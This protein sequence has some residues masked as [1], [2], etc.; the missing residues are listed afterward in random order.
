MRACVCGCGGE[1]RVGRGPTWCG[2]S[3]WRIYEGTGHVFRSVC[4]ALSLGHQRIPR[5]VLGGAAAPARNLTAAP[6]RQQLGRATPAGGAGAVGGLRQQPACA[7]PACIE[8][9]R[10]LQE[11]PSRVTRPQMAA[12]GSSKHV[13]SLPARRTVPLSSSRWSSVCSVVLHTAPCN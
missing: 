7:V 4:S 9:Q 8:T 10:L 6:G 3:R 11:S 12:E 1:G 5:R 2:Q 13:H